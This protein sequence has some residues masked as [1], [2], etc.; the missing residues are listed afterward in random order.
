MR[1]FL[2]S[3]LRGSC[4]ANR[5][6]RVRTRRRRRLRRSSEQNATTVLMDE[7]LLGDVV[8]LAAITLKCNNTACK[9]CPSCVVSIAMLNGGARRTKPA[10][11]CF[12]ERSRHGPRAAHAPGPP[13][14][15]LMLRRRHALRA[16]AAGG[17]QAP[18]PPP[19]GLR[20]RPALPSTASSSPGLEPCPPPS[21]AAP[22]AFASPSPI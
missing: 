17:P 18:P 9:S 22:C 7:R 10:T 6:M 3:T 4:N 14:P 11:R 16:A 13:H 15:P 21:S 1:R 20:R 2:A 5:Y 8:V 12:S 19:P